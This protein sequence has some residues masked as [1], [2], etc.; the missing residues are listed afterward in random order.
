MAKVSKNISSNIVYDYTNMT[1][2][3]VGAKH[4]VTDSELKKFETV[5]TSAHE[6]RS[7]QRKA[8]ELPFM[9]LPSK[10]KEAQKIVEFAKTESK[11]YENLV[12]LGIGGSSL[13]MIALQTALNTS[14]YNLKEKT[15][16]KTP[17]VFVE[18]N[19]DPERIADMLEVINPKKTLFNVISKSGGTAET[20]SA[21]MIAREMIAKK[22]GAS[23]VKEHIIA[24]T[25]ARSGI[26]RKITDEEGFRSFIVPDGVGGRFSVLTP[27][28]LLPAAFVGIDI[29]GL[30]EGAA[31]MD[32]RCRN[33]DMTK[34]PALLSAAL[35]YIA[36]TKKGKHI[37][38]MMPYSNALK[39]VADWYRQLW[40]ES[41]GKK[42]SLAG[43]VVHAGQT[44]IKA[45][46]ATDQ[47]SQVQLYNEG[48][49]DKTFT[50][51]R[52]E[53][54]RK[55]ITIP[56]LYK[57][58]DGIA[59][60]G[61]RKMSE[62]I[63]AEQY[64]TQIA[65]TGF[66]RP[67]STIVMPEISANTIGQLLYML[68]MQTAYAGVFYGIDAFDQPGVEAGKIATYALMGR[69]GFEKEAEKINKAVGKVKKR[70]V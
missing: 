26:M 8:G 63:N 44:P 60:L 55:D 48:P 47:H 36:D 29:M 31:S 53:N 34:N 35:Q 45:L 67:N 17:R 64:A 66:N 38:V 10:K 2:G 18:D 59:Y 40:A 1:S 57:N 25:D 24:T 14:F 9:D 6:L 68:E 37:Q 56:K 52:V 61:G 69:P 7:A 43:K 70:T 13:G 11:K 5:A 51:I 21:F 32:R 4:G 49:N 30:L 54:F 12:V 3:A 23:A 15:S 27:V 58:I 39:D 42:Y 20:M 62:L 16:R 65:V 50:F 46:G 28:G 19:V 22:V 41:L 33:S